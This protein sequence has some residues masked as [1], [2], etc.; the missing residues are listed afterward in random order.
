MHPL[1]VMV[2][3][4]PEHGMYSSSASSSAIETYP[5]LI[6]VQPNFSQML[7]MDRLSIH[8]TNESGFASSRVP[9]SSRKLAKKSDSVSGFLHTIKKN[10]EMFKSG[11]ENKSK[12]ATFCE[13]PDDLLAARA[14]RIIMRRGNSHR[15][16]PTR[17]IRRQRSSIEPMMVIT[18]F[19]STSEDTVLVSVA[20][21]PSPSIPKR[22]GAENQIL[23]I[24]CFEVRFVIYLSCPLT[25]VL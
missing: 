13:V 2:S 19:E 16:P 8:D 15:P 23:S 6:N 7:N 5:E 17:Y 18:T 21:N 9:P 4:S 3:T 20:T 22:S 14:A 24:K 10:P 11:R 12:I 25:P 1:A